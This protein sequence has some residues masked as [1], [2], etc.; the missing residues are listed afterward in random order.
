MEKGGW[1][2]CV[3]EEKGKVSGIWYRATDR[4]EMCDLLVHLHEYL[5]LMYGR[6]QT[7]QG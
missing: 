6:K 3:Q 1:E 2:D 4:G 5:L 7:G